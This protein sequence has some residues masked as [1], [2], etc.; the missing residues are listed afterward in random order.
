MTYS[1]TFNNIQ[2]SGFLNQGI[3]LSI[4]L[5]DG[6]GRLAAWYVDPITIEPVKG[7]GFIGEVKQGGSVNFRNVSFNP[8]GHGTHTECLGHITPNIHSVNQVLKAFHCP[9]LLVTLTPSLRTTADA[10][11]D[12]N[13]LVFGFEAV[14]SLPNQLPEA[15]IVRTLPNQEDKKLFVY[16]NTNPPYFLVEFMLEIRR[17]GVKHLLIDL[18]SVDRES[19]GGK[20]LAHHAFWNVPENPDFDRTITELIYVPNQCPD[21]IYLLN[22]QMAPFENDA[23]PSRPVIYPAKTESTE[24]K[25]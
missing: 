12:I 9:A 19:D 14:Q 24:T 22:L 15:L 20:L 18:P 13:D 17:R 6:P 11:S 5:V 25:A 10:Y 16:N 8:H 7:D 21:G 1:F 4:P 3:D 23:S 2:Y